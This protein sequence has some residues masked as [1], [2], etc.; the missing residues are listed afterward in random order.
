V[1][2]LDFKVAA[3]VTAENV[4]QSKDRC[5]REVGMPSFSLSFR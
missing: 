5:K 4:A 1:L 3:K 2:F